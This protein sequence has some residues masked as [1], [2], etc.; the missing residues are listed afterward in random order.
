MVPL[1]L[2]LQRGG[3][4]KIGRKIRVLLFLFLLVCTGLVSASLFLRS[5]SGRHWAQLEVLDWIKREYGVSIA[6]QSLEFTESTFGWELTL[7]SILW[8]FLPGSM[9][10]VYEASGQPIDRL[11]L[12]INPL[13]LILDRKP[14]KAISIKGLVL[15]PEI[16]PEGLLFRGAG[17]D[18][19][20]ARLAQW[21]QS[22]SDER[23]AAAW[24]EIRLEDA[25][26][27]L[28]LSSEGTTKASD[29]TVVWNAAGRWSA[30][31]GFN[32]LQL[33]SSRIPLAPLV[34]TGRQLLLGQTRP[35]V[36]ST[37][38]L[39]SRIE[40]GWIEN[41][42]IHC[43]Q[44]F[45]CLG[46]SNLRHLQ[47]KEKNGLPGLNDFSARLE[48][49]RKRLE[50]TIPAAERVLTWSTVYKQSLPFNLFGTRIKV[51]FDDDAIVLDIPTTQGIW[52]SLSFEANA[53]VS[54]P[55]HDPKKSRMHL[56]IRALP[57]RWDQVRSV[58]PD[59]ILGAT[60]M[61]WLRQRLTKGQIHNLSAKLDGLILEFPFARKQTGIFK[62]NADFK[63]LQLHYQNDWPVL[64]DCQG[65]FLMSNIRISL[66]PMT[67]HAEALKFDQG[68][69]EIPDISTPNSNLQLSMQVQGSLDASVHFLRK[70]PLRSITTLIDE[71]GI[72]APAQRT[73]L[74]LLIPLASAHARKD[75][76]L[77]GQT[78]LSTA[79]LALPRNILNAALQDLVLQF[80]QRGV[81][82][83]TADMKYEGAESRLT[84][85][86]D[87]SLAHMDLS[88]K[89]LV[90]GKGL[91]AGMR[92]SPADHPQRIDG[93]LTGLILEKGAAELKL[94]SFQ[95]QG[96]DHPLQVQGHA[97]IKDFGAISPT[98]GLGPD[99][100]GGHGTVTFHLALP[101]DLAVESPS[102]LAGTVDFD[103]KDGSFEKLSATSMALINVANLRLLGINSK[104]VSYPFLKGRLRFERGLVSTDD[105][106]IGLGALEIHAKGHVD[107]VKDALNFEL[108]MIPDLG[109]PAASMAIGLWNPLVGLGLYGYSK[110]HG[111]ASDSRLNRIASQ[112]YRMKGPI[113]KPDISLISILHLKEIIPWT[114]STNKMG[115]PP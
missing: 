32:Q 87:P 106:T 79:T 58:L 65:R 61:D 42:Q 19:S 73:K 93:F 29:D 31:T 4:M 35:E 71:L 109:S 3:F 86:R 14:V 63:S 80:D 91:D 114:Q 24:P 17:L 95:W 101:G 74:D 112:S 56:D 92:F 111:R 66:E 69:L 55:N 43:K 15:K 57:A 53:R 64:N 89:P 5:D 10:G 75:L 72:R 90:P 48:F 50:F 62:V 67:C 59:Q 81:K 41:L 113:G 20:Q 33:S 18:V 44:D 47:W 102:A 103:L 82:G 60:L 99:Y 23:D 84:L 107:Y 27:E 40:R 104:S 12:S 2:G 6:Y 49:G 30:R 37:L 76:T 46:S 100:K 7:H 68:K 97:T 105:A 8:K 85:H 21:L 94:D 52:N 34:Q 77:R 28:Q 38:E 22:P 78:Q 1:Q 98:L 83:L 36:A 96:Q 45:D 108:T 115:A 13:S 54:I 70:T 25:R 16:R 110:F 51:M 9:D 26:V 39:V 11:H 88:V